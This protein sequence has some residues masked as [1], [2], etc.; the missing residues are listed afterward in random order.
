MVDEQWILF[1]LRVVKVSTLSSSIGQPE[2]M[3]AGWTG[4]EVNSEIGEIAG[5]RGCDPAQSLAGCQS[6]G[7]TPGLIVWPVMI[8]TL[9]MTRMMT[10]SVL[11][12]GTV[13]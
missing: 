7:S 5:F 4:S 2:E 10:H 8:N 11:N 1:M 13:L 12:K 3:Q 9:L 6:V